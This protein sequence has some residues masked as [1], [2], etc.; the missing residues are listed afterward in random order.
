MKK[1]SWKNAIFNRAAARRFTHIYIPVFLVLFI[2]LQI[3]AYFSEDHN[4]IAP[5]TEISE[6]RLPLVYH[7]AYNIHF[8]GLEKLH[9]FDSVKYQRT[10]DDLIKSGVVTPESFYI[11]AKITDDELLI[12]HTPE[13][14]KSL[15][16]SWRLARITEL[17]FLRF[18]PSKLSYNTIITP[19]KYQ[20]GGS[21][22]AGEL[23]LH[24]GWA[25]NLGG[26]LHHASRDNGEGFCPLAD[27]SLSIKML[28]QKHPE[29]KKVMII[30]LDAHQGN[31][32]ERDFR[33][34]PDV[35]TIDLYNE[36]IFPHDT[37]A[38]KGID[39]NV[40][41]EPYTEDL[42]YLQAVKK[43]LA[44]GL[45]EFKPDVIYYIAGSDILHGDPLGS[46]SI[47]PSGMGKRDMLVFQTAKDHK[48]PIVMLFGGGYQKTNAAIIS[49]S[50][51][52]VIEL[53]AQD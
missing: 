23:A 24:Y 48:I 33:D 36:A 43:S 50:I 16:S 20:T 25:V 31:G 32:H 37:D 38:K 8:M 6:T 26:G 47:S 39:L 22:L 9:P 17:G 44:Q 49:N 14:L 19:M 35:Y 21:V 29:I 11:P 3:A 42:V 18:F 5:V 52:N 40:P 12:A 10:Y 7:P 28:R 41:L 45:K 46:L 53:Y 2:G 1:I 30:D 13:Y 27:I 51:Q 15:H 34:D 4:S